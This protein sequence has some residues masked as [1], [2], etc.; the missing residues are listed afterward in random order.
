[1]NVHSTRQT[2]RFMDGTKE[3][4]FQ[5]SAR[6]SGELYVAVNGYGGYLSAENC[7]ELLKFLLN[8][9]VAGFP[10]KAG[11]FDE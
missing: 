6:T 8:N 3:Y 2:L 4:I 11:P 5:R 7:L 1:M 9:G 10:R